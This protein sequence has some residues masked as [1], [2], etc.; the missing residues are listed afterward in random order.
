LNKERL[1]L[2]I[3]LMRLPYNIAQPAYAVLP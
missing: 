2:Y 3:D 1:A